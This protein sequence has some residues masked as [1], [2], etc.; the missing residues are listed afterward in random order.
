MSFPTLNQEVKTVTA[1]LELMG[2]QIN[3][4]KQDAEKVEG[5]RFV[6][7]FSDFYENLKKDTDEIVKKFEEGKSNYQKIL[8]AFGEE[9]KMLPEEFFGIWVKFIG[10]FEVG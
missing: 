7:A 3:L 8:Q 9:S 10:N 6:E 1:N 5:D 2:E 4:A